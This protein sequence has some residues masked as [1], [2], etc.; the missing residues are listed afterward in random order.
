MVL[1]AE[2]GSVRRKRPAAVKLWIAKGKWEG[3]S[4][5][6]KSEDL[7]VR[8]FSFKYSPCWPI[9]VGWVSSSVPDFASVLPDLTSQL[10]SP[11]NLGGKLVLRHSSGRDHCV[12]EKKP[13]KSSS[14]GLS[15]RDNDHLVGLRNNSFR[16]PFAFRGYQ[17]SL[18]NHPSFEYFELNFRIYQ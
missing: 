18:E 7:Q 8:H 1:I 14:G 17:R 12:L 15:C 2:K 5:F 4:I 13:E 6:L 10:P 9:S 16:V 3:A 11:F